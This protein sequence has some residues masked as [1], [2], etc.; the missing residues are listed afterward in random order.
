MLSV[1][2]LC[3]SS[4][5]HV[6]LSSSIRLHSVQLCLD[7]IVSAAAR[8]DY[9]EAERVVAEQLEGLCRDGAWL[10]SYMVAALLLGKEAMQVTSQF[11]YFTIYCML[12][13]HCLLV[14]IHVM[15]NWLGQQQ[16]IP[17]NLTQQGPYVTDLD[18]T[19]AAAVA[20]LL[21][22]AVVSLGNTKQPLP[23]F[24]SRYGRVEHGILKDNVELAAM[25]PPVST[26]LLLMCTISCRRFCCSL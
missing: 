10:K 12:N 22:M 8:G 20:C 6:M 25:M 17:C 16:R 4:L 13:V 5:D 3:V 1:C 11:Y 15:Y 18:A 9:F 23:G 7:C 21:Q 24:T 2:I 19:V 26:Y 14:V